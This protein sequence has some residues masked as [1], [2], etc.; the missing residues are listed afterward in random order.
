MRQT[1][2]STKA[3]RPLVIG[4][5]V[6]DTLDKPD[7]VQ[8]YTQILGMWLAEQGHEVHY[9]VGQSTRTDYPNVH[10]MCRNVKVRFNGNSLTIPLFTP[11]KR[12]RALFA[13]TK[14]DVL[15]VMMP[16]SPLMAQKVVCAAPKSTAVVGTFHILPHT[17][18]VAYMTRLLGIWLRPSLRR[19]QQTVAVSGVAQEFARAT[20]GID[21]SFLP[22][23]IRV[24]RF[25]QAQPFPRYKD[26][27]TIVRVDRLVERKGALWLVKAIDY[28]VQHKLATQ[29]FRLVLC[30]KGEQQETIAAYIAEHKLSKFIAL[31]GYISEEDKPRYLASSDLA[32]Y[33]ATGGESFGI[34]LL[35][36]MAAS[37]GVVIGG[38]NPGYRSVIGGHP[39]QLVDPTNTQA[40]AELIARYINDPKL[41]KQAAL[42]QQYDVEQYDVA[43]VGKQLE[44][45]YREAMQTARRVS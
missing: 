37:R 1:R 39:E 4:L 2:T 18:T 42:W 27:V 22:N 7:G 9:I 26:A 8:Q 17:K 44:S 11:R 25:K 23:V 13:E 33:P 36:A 20:F 45:I 14:F 24:P 34:V 5:V 31:E 43:V 12:I 10:S 15:H 6:D 28:M 29:P 19:M 38:D 32:I 21:P 35:E 3:K 41:R 30:G 16:H 40:F